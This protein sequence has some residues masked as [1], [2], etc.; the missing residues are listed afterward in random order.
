M[1]ER[2]PEISGCTPGTMPVTIAPSRAPRMVP[3][4]MP[5]TTLRPYRPRRRNAGVETETCSGPKP[6]SLSFPRAALASERVL[7]RPTT[8][9]GICPP[10]HR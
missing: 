6:A 1:A 3:T 7:K 10:L 5:M 4:T 9:S 8:V 2:L